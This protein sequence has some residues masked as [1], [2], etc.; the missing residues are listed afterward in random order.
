MSVFNIAVAVALASVV[1]FYMGMRYGVNRAFEVLV[2][3][4]QEAQRLRNKEG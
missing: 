4:Q 1:S 2:R 3:V